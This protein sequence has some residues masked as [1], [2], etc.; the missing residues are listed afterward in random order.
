MIQLK[1][2]LANLEAYRS[3]IEW[4]SRNINTAEGRARG[5]QAADA[6]SA[7]SVENGGGVKP[8][9][10]TEQKDTTKTDKNTSQVWEQIIRYMMAANRSGLINLC[11]SSTPECRAGCLGHTSGRLRFN[12]QQ[13]AQYI[14]TLF[15]VTDPL[16]FH[17]FELKDA[18]KHAR[19]IH[20]KGYKLAD[21]HNG[22][23]DIAYEAATWYMDCLARVGVDVMF[24]YTAIVERGRGWIETDSDMPYHLTASTKETTHPSAVTPT[25]YTVVD[26]AKGQALPATYNGYPVADGDKTDMRFLDEPGHVTLGRAKGGL[27]G[28]VGADDTFVKSHRY[29]TTARRRLTVV[30]V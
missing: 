20:K 13:R 30:A 19:R 22:T 12:G 2:Y 1:T 17:I 28:L 24:D 7:L 21:R 23:S 14:R 8:F 10:F 6:F 18:A 11:P 16:N 4:Y 26:V 27:V 9:L 25:S 5:K 15:M 3:E 29:L